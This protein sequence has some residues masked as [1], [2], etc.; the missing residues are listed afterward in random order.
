[1]TALHIA[2]NNNNLQAIQVLLADERV[3]PNVEDQVALALYVLLMIIYH[4]CRLGEHHCTM[5]VCTTML[6]W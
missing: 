5:R 6:K 2:A 3:N 1:M 4:C